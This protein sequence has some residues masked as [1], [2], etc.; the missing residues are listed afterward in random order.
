MNY[1][2][3]LEIKNDA[4]KEEIKKKYHLLSKKYHPDK[5]NGIDE[6]FKKIKEAYDILYDDEMRKK[7]DIQLL[8]GDINFTEE[9]IELLDKYYKKLINSQE[10]KLL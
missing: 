5:N 6:H 9:D 3:I 8:F 10:F 2:E 1:Y 4:T 7:Y